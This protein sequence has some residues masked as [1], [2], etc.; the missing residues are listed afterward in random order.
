[1]YTEKF[2]RVLDHKA[3]ISN[4][5]TDELL[6]IQEKYPYFQLLAM[7]S[8]KAVKQN[9][10]N[11]YKKQLAKVAT[12][13]I[14]R[15]VLF[16]YIY[17]EYSAE[18]SLSKKKNT[19]EK[20]ID[21]KENN[22][23]N[24][25]KKYSTPVEA[26]ETHAPELIKTASDKEIKSKA[27]L[28]SEV[29]ARLNEINK[30]AKPGDKESAIME[31]TDKSIELAKSV[32]DNEN[33]KIVKEKHLKYGPIGKVRKEVKPIDRGTSQKIIESFIKANPSINRPEDK[34]YDEELL[35]ANKSL[36]ESYDLVS[37]T[38]AELFV[39]QGYHKKAI[40]VYE[41]LILIYPEK[42]TYFA[43]RILKLKN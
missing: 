3:D 36:E 34:S 22:T 9:M 2:Y 16:D 41:K 6:K 15:E 39:K 18:K 35:L 31:S 29:K 1:M 43:A 28:M 7:A 11:D 19:T 8:L 5:D 13:V 42:S 24:I 40:K 21:K 37:E 4:I 38:M 10:P 25:Q 17:P 33:T 23:Q 12:N 32:S 26:K 20:I 14:S 27:E 30:D